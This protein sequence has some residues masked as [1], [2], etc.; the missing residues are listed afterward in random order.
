MALDGRIEAGDMILQVNDISFENLSN[1]EAVDVLRQA[2]TRKGSVSLH[3]CKS[4]NPQLADRSSWSSP[5]AG[6]AGRRVASRCRD[7][8]TSL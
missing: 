8:R 5:S 2:V 1:D 6:R 3:Q 4:D 7:I